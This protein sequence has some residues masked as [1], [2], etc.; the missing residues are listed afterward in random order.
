MNPTP[1]TLERVS[2]A[3]AANGV[4]SEQLADYPILYAFLNGHELTVELRNELL[5]Y[6]FVI[7]HLYW[8]L[9]DDYHDFK[10]LDE[11]FAWVDTHNQPSNL[12]GN[13]SLDFADNEDGAFAA[14]NHTIPARVG[15]TDEQLTA[16]TGRIIADLTKR[17]EIMTTAFNWEEP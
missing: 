6:C 15:I 3:L 9:P 11:V 5:Q 8:E 7:Q 14:V 16:L 13:Y 12:L 1:I 17:V 2:A 4:D 10:N